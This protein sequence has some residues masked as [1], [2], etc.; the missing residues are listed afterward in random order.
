MAMA[1]AVRVRKQTAAQQVVDILTD[2][3]RC[4]E[5]T[6]E[7]RLP[8]ED[9]LA[10]ELGVSRTTIRSALDVLAA[11]HLVFRRHG[12]GT[13]VSNLSRIA[14]PLNQAVLFQDLIRANGHEP[15]IRWL[16]TQVVQPDAALARLLQIPTD[17]PTLEVRKVFTADGE[18]VIYCANYIPSWVLGSSVL[19]EV[20]ANPTIEEPLFGFLESS[21]GHKAVYFV[22]TLCPERIGDSGFEIA[23]I[24]SSTP[25]LKIDEIGYDE[26]ERPVVRSVH[27][28]PGQRMNFVFVRRFYNGAPT[29]SSW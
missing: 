19:E 2:R 21:C 13:F 22:A 1:N 24:D 12:V 7:M 10:D 14:N 15:G 27:H 28:Y 16:N 5:Y 9:G 25:A 23:G 3:I 18:P 11:Q 29:R 8:S 26:R 20:L 6:P 17:H 4:G